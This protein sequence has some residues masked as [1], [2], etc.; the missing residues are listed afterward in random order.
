[1][2][3]TYSSMGRNLTVQ[4]NPEMTEHYAVLPLVSIDAN[5][6]EVSQTYRGYISH[7]GISVDDYC[8]WN[9]WYGYICDYAYEGSPYYY[10][11]KDFTSD[12]SPYVLANNGLQLNNNANPYPVASGRRPFE[13]DD[14]GLIADNIS[15]WQDQSSFF[16][17]YKDNNG[18]WVRGSNLPDGEYFAVINRN[19]AIYT[20]TEEHSQETQGA[21]EEIYDQCHYINETF[22]SISSGS[23]EFTEKEN[24]IFGAYPMESLEYSDNSSSTLTDATTI[25]CY[26][27]DHNTYTDTLRGVDYSENGQG[28]QFGALIDYDNMNGDDYFIVFYSVNSISM[29]DSGTYVPFDALNT[30]GFTINGNFTRNTTEI[31]KMAYKVG[32]SPQI[33]ELGQTILSESRHSTFVGF[34]Q[35][36]YGED[37]P[38]TEG[39]HS[40][41]TSGSRISNVSSQINRSS[42]VYTYSV[43]KWDNSSPKYLFDKRIIGLINISDMSL[44]VGYRQEFELDFSGTDFDPSRLAGIGVTK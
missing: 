9:W 19:K 42:I 18:N 40:T 34:G 32:G 6:N 1:V 39:S 33:T 31:Y 38:I 30:E 21:P 36:E 8:H 41:S 12:S 43:E 16:M 24:F 26:G 17:R 5:G 11:P 22:T 35:D 37:I 29:Q 14:N 7:Y 25:T 4:S 2:N 28:R 10:R 15:V 3:I 44:P 27:F 13:V 23:S 20:T